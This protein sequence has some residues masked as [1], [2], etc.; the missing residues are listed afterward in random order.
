VG[1]ICISPELS[2]GFCLSVELNSL[3]TV[4]VRDKEDG[5]EIK[6]EKRFK[7]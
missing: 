7:Y 1:H 2:D 5:I 4:A 6:M 3:L